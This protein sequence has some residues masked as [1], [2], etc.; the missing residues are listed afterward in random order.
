MSRFVLLALLVSLWSLLLSQAPVFFEDWEST[1]SEWTIVN[2]PTAP[3]KW[4]CGSATANGGSNSMY[5]SN[6]Q[7]I[8]NA[9]QT[10]FSGTAATT[11][12]HFYHDIA[13]PVSDAPISLIFDIRSNG[14][15]NYDFMRIY[16]MPTSV[17]PE[18]RNTSFQ[19]TA[20][21]DPLLAYMIGHDRYNV[22][23]LADTV[24]GWHNETIYISPDWAGQEGR[25]V[26]SWI[27]DGS[28]GNQPPGAIDNISITLLEDVDQPLPVTI[29]NPKDN[30]RF[31]SATPTLSWLPNSTGMPPT[32]Y[33]V[34]IDTENP[35]TSEGVTVGRVTTFT[36]E[37]PLINA[38]T[39][40]WTVI[41]YNSGGSTDTE[42]CPIWSFETIEPD[43]LAIGTGTNTANTAPFNMS[44]DYSI[45]QTIYL[46]SEIEEILPGS[47]ITALTYHYT[48]TNTDLNENIDIYMG[49]TTQ[50]GFA[51]ANSW[52]PVSSLTHVYSGAIT[53]SQPDSYT[54]IT[55]N[56]NPFIYIEGNLVVCVTEREPDHD[57]QH[58]NSS[59]Y[60]TIYPNH[61]RSINYNS[62]ILSDIE[63]PDTG[64][65]TSAIPNT[66]ISYSPPVGNHLFLQPTTLDIGGINQNRPATR[67]IIFR[68][69]TDTINGV[70]TITVYDIACS[71][72]ITTTQNFPFSIEP[73]VSLPIT[74]TILYPIATDDFIGEI[75][76]TSDA[77][78]GPTHLASLKGVIYP[79][80]MVE[81]SGGTSTPVSSI[82][83]DHWSRYNYSQSIYL[84]SDIERE[85]GEIITQ[86]Q[87]HYNAYIAYTQEVSIYMG[88]T[89]QPEFATATVESLV[90]INSLS[91]VYHGPFV[92]STDIDPITGGYW[93]N[94]PLDELFIYDA[95]QNLVIAVL[96][97]QSGPFGGISAKFYHK[98]TSDY[99]SIGVFDNNAPLDPQDLSL[100]PS[101]YRSIPNMRMFFDSAAQGAYI[102]TSQRIIDFGNIEQNTTQ[103]ASVSISNLGT[104]N[105]VIDSISVPADMQCGVGL[106]LI[107]E[108]SGTAN[109][110][111]AFTPTTDGSYSEV[112]TIISN[113]INDQSFTISIIASVLPQNIFYV[114]DGTL[115]DQGLPFEPYY[116]YSYSQTIYHR[117]DLQ[118]LPDEAQITHIGYQ[119]NGNSAFSQNVRIYIGHTTRNAYTL[120]NIYSFIPVHTHT[121]VYDGPLTV[122]QTPGSWTLLP[123]SETILYDATQNLVVTVNEYQSG[124]FAPSSND[125]YCTS[126]PS[127]Q[128]IT[129]YQNLPQA[130]DEFD[131]AFPHNNAIYTR[132]AI[133]NTAFSFIPT[134]SGLPKPRD[135]MGYVDYGM[136]TLSWQPPILPSDE[137]LCPRFF[138][139]TVY[140][141]GVDIIGGLPFD[142]T[143]YYDIE[144]SPNQSYTYYVTAFYEEGESNPSNTFEAQALSASDENVVAIPTKLGGN[145]PNP[146]NPSTVIAFSLAR[147]GHI[148]IDIFNAKG[149][150]VKNLT[151]AVLQAGK[152]N[153]IWNGDDATGRSVGS[154]VYFYRMTT[155]GYSS[156]QKMLLMK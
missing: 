45:S 66:I 108:P 41:P 21:T 149:Q 143:Y 7:G 151:N 140:R 59:W 76:V 57:T 133:P 40:Y 20:T 96:E 87:Y 124:A 155:E 23:T 72:G 64:V 127:A 18:A 122:Q 150:K 82:P 109:I 37:N 36:P 67:D 44:T 144:V 152:H 60:Q 65:R 111:L 148:N 73:N 78:N 153:V 91:L 11:V 25:L 68:S 88:Y 71:E 62:N 131:L 2:H 146:F 14:E 132:S 99:R 70:P 125:F 53:A 26:F 80:N 47:E 106:P 113:A 142:T 63:N 84:P 5:I 42:N 61:F 8:S 69:V 34:Y 55:L 22:S 1:G 77:D 35:P 97:N 136:V 116:V 123:L 110:S 154:G 4:I 120:N 33:T 119:Y 46:A 95:S 126:T 85:D 17:I 16:L 107:I 38:T 101:I 48:S 156:V 39:Y 134:G 90:P 29:I 118:R 104:E 130:F 19:A 117:D 12:A 114:G 30:T 139:Y 141:N 94:I 32:G 28:A 74:F 50:N 112:I 145:Y 27:N 54:T 81:I 93:V 103:Q 100:T 75:T 10:G 105:L 138:G 6:D 56:M 3:N 24:G 51:T 128:S 58:S 129:M 102:A 137:T 49:H 83:L 89:D 13:F 86:I 135:L 52:V 92:M 121:L 15:N 9:Y 98:P 31:V 43:Q 147:K 79:E 115:I